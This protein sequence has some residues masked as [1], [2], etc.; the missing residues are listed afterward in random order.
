MARENVS[1][2]IANHMLITFSKTD[3]NLKHNKIES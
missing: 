3:L 1:G 2:M